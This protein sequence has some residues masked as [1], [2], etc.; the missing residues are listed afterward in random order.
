MTDPVEMPA[1][2]TP[3]EQNLIDS[4]RRWIHESMKAWAENDHSK[5]AVVAPMA[6]EHLGKAVLWRTNPVLLVPLQQEAESSL[7][8]LATKPDLSMPRLRTI[9]LAML[10]NRLEQLIGSLPVEKGRR[11]RLVVS[12]NGEVHVGSSDQSRYVLMDCLSLC[13]RLADHLQLDQRD[14][15]GDHYHD[16]EGLLQEKRTEV[17][18]VVAAKKA[19]AR[20]SLNDLEQRL[21]TDAFERFTTELEAGAEDALRPEDFGLSLN[22][23]SHPCPECSSGGRLFG[24]V[25]VESEPDWDIEPMGDGQYHQYISGTIWVLKFYPQLFSCNVCKIHLSGSEELVETGLPSEAEVVDEDELDDSFDLQ[26]FSE[27]S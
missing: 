13:R 23:I 24:R 12:R 1:E 27:Y 10:L 25:D 7:L 14:F 9:G 2:I 22:S 16:V 18:H 5:V 11:T 17:G 15:F 26:S 21:G 3:P 19:R 8:N 4:A 20:N 6:V